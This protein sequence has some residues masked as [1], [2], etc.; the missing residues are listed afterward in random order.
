MELQ[1]L[2]AHHR[3]RQIIIKEEEKTRPVCIPVLARIRGPMLPMEAN[4]EAAQ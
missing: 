1:E 3:L 2:N 4:L